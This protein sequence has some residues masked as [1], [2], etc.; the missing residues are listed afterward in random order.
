METED[1]PLNIPLQDYKP[2][3]GAINNMNNG[4]VGES[5]FRRNIP[6][7]SY[8]DNLDSDDNVSH[9]HALR[10]DRLIYKFRH[11]SLSIAVSLTVVLSVIACV[12]SIFAMIKYNDAAKELRTARENRGE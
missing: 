1:N 11:R 4:E 2:A 6:P 10:A 8:S 9:T 5:G 12:L 7:S 3:A